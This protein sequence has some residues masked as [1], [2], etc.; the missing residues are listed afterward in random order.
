MTPFNRFRTSTGAFVDRLLGPE[1]RSTGEVMGLSDNF[2]TAY[3]KSQDAGGGPLPTT[4]KLFV[5]IADRDKRH[6]IWPIKRLVDLG[7]QVL[8]TA[9][10]ASVLRRNG[11]AAEEVRKL[12]E[13]AEGDNQ[14]SI[15]ELIKSGEID[16]IFNTPEG[17]SSGASTRED[18]YLIRTAA[19]LADVP[20]VTTVPGL[21]AATQGI[22]ALQRGEVGV[23]SLQDWAAR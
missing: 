11:V 5:S 4:G 17:S 12:S 10:T 19:V 9:G 2:G 7:F 13:M 1:M 20:L 21:A 14:P 16:L 8:A 15:V 3:A 23:Q 18:G 22:E 6:A